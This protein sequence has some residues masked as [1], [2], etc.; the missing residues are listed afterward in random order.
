MLTILPLGAG[1]GWQSPCTNECS[2]IIYIFH[3]LFKNMFVNYSVHK[4]SFT[5]LII[6]KVLQ[7]YAAFTISLFLVFPPAVS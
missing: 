3:K 4:R 1:I 6:F 2:V 5:T 7:S